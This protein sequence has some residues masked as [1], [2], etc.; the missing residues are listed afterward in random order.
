TPAFWGHAATTSPRVA[1]MAADSAHLLAVSAWMG[2]LACL[3]LVLPM[4]LRQAEPAEKASCLATAVP[5][6]SAIA[7]A[8]VGV[9]MA[10]GTYLAVLQVTAWSALVRST[11]GLVVLAKI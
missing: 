9:P 11:Y 6:F 1:S 3:V 7:L 4:A 5:R 8:A 2:G 10:S